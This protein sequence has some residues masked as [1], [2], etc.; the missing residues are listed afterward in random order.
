LQPAQST[1]HL[2]SHLYTQKSSILWKDH[3]AWFLE[4]VTSTFTSL[5]SK[6]PVTQRRK[7]FLAL[8][9]NLEPR[10]SVYR[11]LL[12]L[13]TNH[14]NLFPFIDV[15]LEQARGLVCDPMPP[16]T[17]VNKYD[18]GYFE[19]VDDLVSFGRRTRREQAMDERRLAQMI[20]DVNFRQQLQVSFFVPPS[21]P[22][23]GL[24]TS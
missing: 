14:R 10:Y 12:V 13:E 4:T 2:L 19:H 20:P 18:N 22:G 16:T 1:L 23:F 6:L 17:A 24:N 11:H 21:T 15:N 7:D 5:P 8:Y 3:S 9:Q